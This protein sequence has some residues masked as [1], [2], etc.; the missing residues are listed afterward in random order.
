MTRRRD[1]LPCLSAWYAKR[2]PLLP[3]GKTNFSDEILVL[4]DM[5]M[6][7]IDPDGTRPLVFPP[8]PAYEGYAP[9]T[10][11]KPTGGKGTGHGD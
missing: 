10:R 4:T 5:L 9:D 2:F 11:V 8:M 7:Q 6:G 3:P 1:L